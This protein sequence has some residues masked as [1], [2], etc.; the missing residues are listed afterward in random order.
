M[1]YVEGETPW[2]EGLVPSHRLATPPPQRASGQCLQPGR[3]APSTA[4]QGHAA[5]AQVPLESCT[6]HPPPLARLLGALLEPAQF[7]IAVQRLQLERQLSGSLGRRTSACPPVR[8]KPF[9]SPGP[10]PQQSPALPPGATRHSPRTRASRSA[11]QSLLTSASSVPH[12][13]SA[14][15]KGKQINMPR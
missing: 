4:A 11:T 13:Y 15:L 14:R 12:I 9:P 7:A 3:V 2:E 10:K 5:S 1:W 6:T 8:D